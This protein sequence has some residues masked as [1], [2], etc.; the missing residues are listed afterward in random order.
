MAVG[1]PHN[2][3][4][5]SLARFPRTNSQ[6]WSQQST[7]NEQGKGGRGGKGRVGGLLAIIA[8]CGLWPSFYLPLNRKSGGKGKKNS[9]H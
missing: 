1:I 8:S 5:M 9:T 6:S 2:L 4:A 7:E 3:A